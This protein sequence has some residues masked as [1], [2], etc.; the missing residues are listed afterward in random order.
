MRDALRLGGSAV[1]RVNH[2]DDGKF[3]HFCQGSLY[4]SPDTVRFESDNNAHTFETP[5]TNVDT[6]KIDSVSTPQWKNRSVY[7]I[8]LG[9][10]KGRPKFRFSPQTGDQRESEMV[11]RLIRWQPNSPNWNKGS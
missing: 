11:E 4:I 3:T 9:A 7:K 5:R 2:D 6:I 10:E 8:I 1:L